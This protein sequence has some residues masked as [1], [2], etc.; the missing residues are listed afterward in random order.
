MS[1]VLAIFGCAPRSVELEHAHGG[2][3]GTTNTSGAG[4]TTS[5]GSG[6]DAN[7][8]KAGSAG[9]GGK[10]GAG[11]PVGNG[12]EGDDGPALGGS[13]GKGLGGMGNTGGVIDVCADRALTDVRGGHDLLPGYVAAPDPRVA[14]WLATMSLT[15]QITQMEGIPS[16]QPLPD[17]ND[18]MRSPD[19]TLASGTVVRGYW[20]RNGARGV[21]LWA[22]QYKGI[23][24]TDGKDYST[25][26]PSPSIRAA[27]W[28]LDLEWRIGE[29]VGDETT[30]SY[31]N[32]VLTPNL[33]VLRHPLW[34]RAQDAYGEDPYQVGRM[35]TAFVAGV[36]RHVGA[37]AAHFIGNQVERM[38][39]QDNALVDEQSLRDI[40]ARPFEA[41]VRDG[42]V[43]CVL[44]AYNRVNGIKSTVNEHLLRDVLKAPVE[45]GG[46]GFR[47]FVL[48]DWWAAPGDQ[49]EPSAA[50]GLDIAVDMVTAG[51]DVEVPWNLHYQYLADA[52]QES[53]V[54][55]SLIA[56]AAS[57]VLEQKARFYSA[58]STDGWGLTESSSTL[59]VGSIAT[60]RA[61]LALAEQSELESAV[62]LSNGPSNNPVLP[63]RG[64]TTSIA[65]LGTDSEFFIINAPYPVPGSP[66]HFASDVALGDRGSNSINA[67]PEQ[68]VGPFAGISAAAAD[69]GSIEVSAGAA[70]TAGENV[71]MIV[72]VV[73]Y[74][75]ADEGEEFN[76]PA[77]GDRSSLHLPPEQEILI[78]QVLDLGKPTVIVI[79]SGSMVDVSWLSHANQNQ[80]TIWAGYGGM[81]AGAAL[82]KLLFGDASFSGKLPFA[83]AAESALPSFYYG[84]INDF[85]ASLEYFV[86]Y[87][88]YD[89]RTAAGENLD[90]PFPFGHGLSYTTFA[91]D[92]FVVPCGNVTPY[93]VLDVTADITNTGSVPG[94]E[95]AFLFVK[96]PTV[97]ASPRSL[98]ELKS[99]AR[100]SLAPG[101]TQTVHLPVRIQDLKH[102]STAT[103]SY[104]VDPGEYTVLVGPSGAEE[105]LTV[106]GTFTIPG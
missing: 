26:Y 82:G 70:V 28:D 88:D 75:P 54:S 50:D 18:V 47:G 66:F 25:A 57:R 19:A 59:D 92:N 78:A 83:W 21:N 73:G 96:G 44:A 30:A 55:S 1:I 102:W 53:Q 71:D 90:I 85:T 9:R 4:G 72:V 51:L 16:G 11:A 99:F 40:Y 20:Y 74:T 32:L 98:K 10:G 5:A 22:G 36:Q 64:G 104:G 68:A 46:F 94:D 38:R 58:L 56:D 12:G 14:T 67:D 77:G 69:H 29:A 39:S 62:L 37:C 42:G 13:G 61:H 97:D 81:R 101:A 89:R 100:V 6:A 31:N 60:N 87:R 7:G 23:R 103:S 106:A 2:Q 79:E 8:A 15:D 33:E 63:I 49:S 93:A 84:N 45:Q 95:V 24:P 35:G 27:S 80:A 91:Y 34:G 3:G 86:G 48:S 105:E 17:Y 43:A 76:V 65:V 41:V 52:V